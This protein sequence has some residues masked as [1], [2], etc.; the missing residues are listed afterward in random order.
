MIDPSGVGAGARGRSTG[1]RSRRKGAVGEAE[2]AAA[3]GAVLGKPW[4][5]TAQRWGK[6]K[7]DIEPCDGGVGVHVEVKRV[8]SLLKRWSCSVQEHPL[9]LGGELYCCSIENLVLMLDQVEIPRI[10]AKSSTV[11]RYMAQ[12]VRDAEDGLVPMVMCRMDHGPWLVCWRYDDDDRLTA[13]LREAM[14]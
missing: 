1:A 3:L 6:A 10:C 11:M 5:R 9:I 4:R 14:K 8:G 12:A 7:A 13:A 2:A